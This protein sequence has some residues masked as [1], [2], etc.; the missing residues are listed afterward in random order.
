MDETFCLQVAWIDSHESLF[1]LASIYCPLFI[2]INLLAQFT[3][4]SAITND[5]LGWDVSLKGRSSGGSL[6]F[7]K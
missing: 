1:N 5:C 3:K 4:L 7:K 6:I 2:A